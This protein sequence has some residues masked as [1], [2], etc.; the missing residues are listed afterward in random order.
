MLGLL[1]F[2]KLIL[3]VLL[4]SGA[5]QSC[6]TDPARRAFTARKNA[7]LGLTLL[8]ELFQ[9]LGCLRLMEPDGASG[10]GCLRSEGD[11]KRRNDE[12]PPLLDECS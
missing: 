8:F 1:L 7:V 4:V 5:G 9:A 2:P 6:I 10:V 12:C 11:G 3:P